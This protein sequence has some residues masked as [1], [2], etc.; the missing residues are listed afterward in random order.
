MPA[1]QA[2]ENLLGDVF[3]G[4]RS[5]ASL[6]PRLTHCGLSALNV[7]VLG[8]WQT[9]NGHAERIPSPLRHSG[10][11]TGRSATTATKDGVKIHSVLHCERFFIRF[12]AAVMYLNP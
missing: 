11:R 3:L 4:L 5:S 6:Q 7:E 9:R 8:N 12:S 2:L 10:C 1:L